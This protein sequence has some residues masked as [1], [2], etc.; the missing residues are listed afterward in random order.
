GIFI[1]STDHS[2]LFSISVL[3][4]RNP[5]LKAPLKVPHKSVA[6]ATLAE[7][8]ATKTNR[9]EDHELWTGATEAN[10][11]GLISFNGGT[12]TVS[13]VVWEM[14]HGRL[15]DGARIIGL[16]SANPTCVR[17]EHLAVAGS[18]QARPRRARKGAGSL[19]RLGAG[20][21]EL[22]VTVGRWDD[23]RARTF[24]R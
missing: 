14:A 24:Y 12:T 2:L 23:G 20:R 10:V 9:R 5:L 18:E 21:W 4:A 3:H 16:C 13:R 6:V 19:R 22:R 7:R 17:L 8:L 15:P 1:G 11:N